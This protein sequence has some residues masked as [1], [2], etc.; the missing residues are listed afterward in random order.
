MVLKFRNLEKLVLTFSK[1]CTVLYNVAG[2][3]GELGDSLGHRGGP[4]QGG[5]GVVQLL[6]NANIYSYSSLDVLYFSRKG[7][8]NLGY[9]VPLI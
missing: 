7:G 6:Q 8:R 9:T 4:H 5:R 1:Y 2:Y 3:G